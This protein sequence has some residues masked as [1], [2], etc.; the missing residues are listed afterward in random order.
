MTAIRIQPI[1]DTDKNWINRILI[2]RWGSTTIVTRCVI[3]AAD[4]LPGFIAVEENIP[5]G[6][7]MYRFEAGTCEIISLDSLVEG[8]G[9]GTSLLKSVEQAAK[10]KECNRIWLITTNDNLRALRFYQRRGYVLAALHRDAIKR[11]RQLKP[12]IPIVGKDGI[13]LRDEIELEKRL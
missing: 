5:V 6:L 3:H 7:L 13:P 4:E 10:E 1:R 8:R 12:Q 11:S 2:D 9:I